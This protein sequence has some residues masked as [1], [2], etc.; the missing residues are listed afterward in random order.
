MQPRSGPLARY[1]AV[2]LLGFLAL[3]LLRHI[4]APQAVPGLLAF[5]PAGYLTAVAPL[6]PF[7]LLNARLG[8]PAATICRVELG[9][10]LALLFFAYARA[11]QLA[12]RGPARRP[13][14]GAL[15]AGGLL[16]SLPLIALPHML[17]RDVYSYIIYGR[18]AALHGANPAILPP[19]AFADDPYFHFLVSWKDTPSVYGPLWTLLSHGLTL[20]VEALG[21]GLWRYMLAYKLVM[22][23]AHL[24]NSLLIWSILGAWKPWQQG[25]GTLIYA[26]N[27]VALI[28]FA[29]SGH[30][31]VLMIGLILLAVFLAQ[32]ARWRAAVAAL[33]GAALI[34]WAALVLLPIYALML[35]RQSPSWRQRLLRAAQIGA[36]V[37]LCALA[38]HAPY[39]QVARAISAPI[40]TQSAMKPENSLSALLV[41]GAPKVLT[42]LGAPASSAASWR[43]AALAAQSWGGKALVGL[44]LLVA[45]YR[46]WRRPSFERFVQSSC[47]LLLVALLVAPV[48]R[49][50]YVTWPLALAPLLGW[51]PLGRLVCVFSATAPLVYLH[52]GPHG[53]S[54]A[55]VFLPVIG[56]LAYQLRQERQRRSELRGGALA[57][58]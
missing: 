50:W 5:A 24:L 6:N 37:L 12:R 38:L 45:L 17:S 20:A 14:L 31:D 23:A 3:F 57:G 35:L 39:G 15:L 2:M 47:W 46:V 49:V 54:D 18:I 33:T 56:M 9:L 51:R 27:P 58:G 11:I 42:R 13:T 52:W 25:W 53:W 36:I 29:G 32:R 48:F 22:L 41:S 40:A 28:E 7:Q 8:L 19:I 16:F 4:P 44:A 26:W 34:K 21:G 55:L 30:N 10:I 43:G 1:G